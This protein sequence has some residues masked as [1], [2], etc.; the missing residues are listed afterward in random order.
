MANDRFS[1]PEL[2]SLVD[3]DNVLLCSIHR[4]VFDADPI[5][6]FGSPRLCNVGGERLIGT[7][8]RWRDQYGDPQDSYPDWFGEVMG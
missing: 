7:L 3:P 4:H 8:A 5:H 1:V 6:Y 2:I